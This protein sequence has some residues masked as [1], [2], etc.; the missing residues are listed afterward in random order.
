MVRCIQGQ[1]RKV[2]A[3]ARLGGDEFALLL[4]ETDAQ[5]ATSA[6]PRIQAALAEEMNRKGWEVTASI[7]VITCLGEIN[8]PEDLIHMADELMYS[9][10]KNSKDAINYGL[11]SG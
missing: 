3:L 7:G 11:Y 1:L 9:A 6:L 4:P 2:D 8:N 10:K 5:A